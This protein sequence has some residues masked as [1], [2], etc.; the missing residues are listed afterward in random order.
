MNKP[1]TEGGGASTE[2]RITVWQF[3][4]IM[5]Q[6]E[7]V[8][9]ARGRAKAPTVFADWRSAWTEI[10]RTL[11]RLADSDA[12]AFSDLMMNQEVVVRCRDRN[13]VNEVTRAI[14]NVMNQLDQQIR[15]VRGEAKAEEELRFER[16]ELN[17]L[18]KHMRKTGRGGPAARST[19]A[20]AA[21]TRAAG[22]PP[23]NA[24]PPRRGRGR[25]G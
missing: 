13:Q 4:R 23:K 2:L 8:A 12:D 17:A 19:A 6:L 9:R 24:S 14:E 18:L 3:V 10:D 11:T 7:T 15:A 16:R 1:S 21:A 20:K 25:K 22:G 5:V